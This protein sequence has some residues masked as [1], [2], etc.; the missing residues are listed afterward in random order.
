MTYPSD[1]LRD[2]HT[3]ISKVIAQRKADKD[4]VLSNIAHLEEKIENSRKVHNALLTCRVFFQKEA[5]VAQED[6]VNVLSG[7]TSMAL[8]DIFPDPYTCVIETG[9][10]RNSTEAVI[11]FEKDK[12]K[13]EPKDATG[14][15]PIDVGSFAARVAFTHLSQARPLIVA[16]EPFKFVSRN[17]L[18]KCPEMLHMLSEKLGMQFI[19]VSHLEEVIEAADTKIYVQGGRVND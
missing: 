16:D 3:K 4:A 11:L 10:K 8:A 1:C 7:V 5:E 13:V 19:I 6:V 17:L 18:S 14:G 15:G 2:R 9:I 12:V